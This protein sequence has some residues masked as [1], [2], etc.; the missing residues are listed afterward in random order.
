MDSRHGTGVPIR[1]SSCA[2]SQHEG[3]EEA[4]AN[5]SG[6]LNL[7]PSSSVRSPGLEDDHH[8]LQWKHAKVMLVANTCMLVF[9]VILCVVMYRR[10]I[11]TLERVDKLTALNPFSK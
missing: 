8:L 4:A 11:D 6:Q 9:L 3:G 7:V 2:P 10:V 1:L 5:V